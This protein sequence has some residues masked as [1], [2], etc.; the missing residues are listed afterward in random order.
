MALG[1]EEWAC[2]IKGQ[3]ES[4][5]SE[6]FRTPHLSKIIWIGGVWGH[7]ASATPKYISK[8]GNRQKPGYVGAFLSEQ[9]LT[10]FPF[11]QSVDTA[12]IVEL[13]AGV[14]FK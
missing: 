9:L 4:N 11:P 5:F 1:E 14:I 13:E 10:W 12:T 8:V 7:S 2:E 6:V 3:T